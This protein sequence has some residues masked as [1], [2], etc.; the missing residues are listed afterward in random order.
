MGAMMRQLDWSTTPL[1][2]VARWPQSLR[3]AVSILLESRFPMYIAWGPEFTQFYNDRY[4]PILGSTKHP[5]ALGISTRETFREVWSIIGPMFEGVMQGKAVGFEDFLLPLDRHGFV[6]E[7]YFIFSYSP[8]RDESGRVGG[9]LVAVTETTERV[10]GERRLKTLGELSSR[11]V[12]A[13]TMMEAAR[14]AGETLAAN[15][16]DLL[17]TLVYLLDAD[18]KR[19]RLAG[20]SRITLDPAICPEV[21]DVTGT[22]D[23]WGISEVIRTNAAV[24]RDAPAVEIEPAPEQRLPERSVAIPIAH[25]GETRPAGV[26]VCGLSPRLVFDAQYRRFLDLVAGQIAT[27]VSSTRSFEEARAR[28]EALAEIDRAKTAFFSNISH[29]FRTPLTLMLGPLEDALESGSLGP[30]E[31][32]RVHRNAL[33]LLKLVNSLLDFSRIEAGRVQASFEKTDLAVATTDLVSQFRAAIERAGLRLTVTCDSIA[34]PTYVDR[35]LWEKIVLNLVSNAF[36]FTF[37]GEIAVSLTSHGDHVELAVRDTGIGVAPHE[38]PRLFERFHRIEGA[39]SRTHEGSGIG[40]A[41]VHELVRMHGGHIRAESE[42]GKGTTFR[43]TIPTGTA[44]LPADRINATTRPASTALG[45]APFVEEALRWLPDIVEPIRPEPAPSERVSPARILLADDNADMRAYV[46]RLL[47][48]YWTVETVPDGAAAL[49]AVHRQRPDLIVTDVM[50]PGIDGYEL[51][52]RVRSDARTAKIPVLMVSA[53][54]GEE[55]RVEAIDEGADDYLVKPFSARELIARIKSQLALANARQAVEELRDQLYQLFMQ[56]PAPICVVRGDDCVFEMANPL[57][58]QVIGHRDLVGK[59]LLAAMPELTGQGFDN[60]LRE[61]MRTG[62]PNYQ[63]EFPVRLDRRGDGTYEDTYFTFVYAP[64]RTADGSIDRAMVFCMDVTEQVLARRASDSASRAKDDFLA[65]LGHELRNPL[66]PIVTA[67]QLM[68]LRLGDDSKRER[69]IIGRHVD[70][71][72]HLVDDLL[73]VAR[74]TRGSL[75]LKRRHVELSEVIAQAV[76]MSAHSVEQRRHALELSVPKTGLELDADPARLAQVVSNLLT[77][78]AKYTEPG[79]RIWV[80]ATREGKS[81]VL[82]VRDNGVGIAPDVLPQ[83]FDLFVQERQSI[84]RSQ[85]G[86]GLGLAIVRNLVT[87]HGGTITARSAGRGSGSEF[88]VRLPLLDATIA[89]APVAIITG[90]VKSASHQAK[91]DAVRVLIVDDNADAADLLGDM[92]RALGHAVGVAYDGP[93]AIEVASKLQPEIALLDIG[94]P[95]MDGYELGRRLRADPTLSDLLLVAITGY[96]QDSDRQRA[97][98]MGFDRHM[99]KPITFNAVSQIIDNFRK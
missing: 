19:A 6:E 76:E 47:S 22:S 75:D 71:L 21:I 82:T 61:V 64:M 26:L 33:R 32:R 99:V 42:L 38:L 60:L 92:V 28:A 14:I 98:A 90:E 80:T 70:H 18:G 12:E 4:R 83:I 87:M 46:E 13:K 86:L 88:I 91:P 57:Y 73:D 11:A 94:L 49:D 3:T 20:S 25:A 34:E 62:V 7:C 97:K 17:F 5:A 77:N 23:P 1:G 74:I 67:L 79:G 81:A 55:A 51:M 16:G 27:A 89:V 41:L 35:D 93:S 37:D 96:G 53:R 40:L 59:P 72:V 95:M 78:A 52:R 44:H 65:M 10:L 15:A 69:A 36:K 43:V 63:R 50:M 24:E 30:E 39:R 84:E 54:A 58:E 9:V 2:D 31:L 56:A 45:T 8:I 66:A 68:E 29:E 85:G 48:Q